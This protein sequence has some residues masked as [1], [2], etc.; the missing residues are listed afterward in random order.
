[1][2]DRVT[3]MDTRG[4]VWGLG[5]VVAEKDLTPEDWY[6]ACHFKDDPVMPGTLLAEGGVQV[7][8][9]YMLYCG[10]Q[11]VVKD[12]RFQPIRGLRQRVRCRKEVNGRHEKV[13]Y[14][15]EVKEA[16]LLPEPYA[17]ADL[18]ILVDLARRLGLTGPLV[19]SNK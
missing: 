11:A 12:A 2:I 18:E 13:V 15:L 17:I 5:L 9:L 3:S 19:I 1:M 10:M 14:R 8:Q 4:G 6:F 7:L 16:A